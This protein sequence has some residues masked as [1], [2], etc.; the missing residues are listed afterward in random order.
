VERL[1]SIIIPAYN[2]DQYIERTLRS[3]SNQTHDNIEIIIVDDGSTDRTREIAERF[4]VDEPRINVISV[5]NGGVARA[6][7]IGLSTARGIFVAFLDADDLWHPTKIERQLLFIDALDPDYAACYTLTRAIDSYDNVTGGSALKPETGYILSRHLYARF[8]GNGSNLLV[9][10]QVAQE[11]GGFDPSYADAG[12]GGCEDFDFELKIAARYR[13]A[14]LPSYLV[15]YRLYR[16]NMSSNQQRMVRSIIETTKR[17]L[18]ANQVLPSYAKAMTLSSSYRYCFRAMVAAGLPFQA[19][20]W[21]VRLAM[22]DF[23]RACVELTSVL[24]YRLKNIAGRF[25]RPEPIM[26]NNFYTFDPDDFVSTQEAR[27]RKRME[28]LAVIDGL[29]WRKHPRGARARRDAG[30]GPM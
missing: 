8:V 20:G 13:M 11:V 23:V 2:A 14:G 16:G 30:G 6:R 1:V 9:R 28:R 5:P 21:L 24:I 19:L 29:L 3:A 25:R 27:E 26:L 22:V 10:T 15:G 12:I 17:H 7:N 18:Q 4:A